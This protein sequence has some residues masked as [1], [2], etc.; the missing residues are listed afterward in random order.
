[1]DGNTHTLIDAKYGVSENSISQLTAFLKP[2]KDMGLNP[3][4]CTT[5]G[6]PQAIQTFKNLWPD[7]ILQ[8]CMVHIQRQ[9]LM[10]CRRKP[11]RED[12]R[13]LR[14]IFLKVP[15]IYSKYQRDQFLDKV[16]RWEQEYGHSI[17]YS[18]D[19]STVMDGL[20]KARSM[21]TNALPNMFYY[22]DNFRIPKTTNCLEGYF[23]RLKGHYRNHRGLTKDK[24]NN[25]FTWYFFFRPK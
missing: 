15:Y 18:K 8:R 4:S 3:I 20:K 1:M 21:L 25:Y 16:R 6:N 5:D 11:T 10:W 12:A 7:I 22:L 13:L 24:L 19:P 17:T 14:N 23:S 2:L 9:G